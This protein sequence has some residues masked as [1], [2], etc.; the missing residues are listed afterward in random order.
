MKY[1]FQKISVKLLF[2]YY[3]IFEKKSDL[4][5]L[6][7][8]KKNEGTKFENKIIF[9]ISYQMLNGLEF[10]HKNRI[11]HRDIKPAYNIHS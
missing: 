5:K 9:Q 7:K 11:I 4:A 2:F 3:F 6:V 1:I 10:L 8:L